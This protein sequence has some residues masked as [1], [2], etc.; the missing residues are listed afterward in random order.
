MDN[1]KTDKNIKKNKHDYFTL[2]NVVIFILIACA[3]IFVGKYIINSTISKS[4]EKEQI[5]LEQTKHWQ[6]KKI[7]NEIND[8]YFT[9]ATCT[10]KDIIINNNPVSL[11]LFIR[12]DNEGI[13]IS[14]LK[15]LESKKNLKIDKIALISD[16]NNNTLEYLFNTEE[17]VYN[18]VDASNI[19]DYIKSHKSLS[20]K[21]NFV[22]ID[23]DYIFSFEQMKEDL[24]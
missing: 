11:R 8:T 15:L 20:L 4:T 16:T 22:A 19:I 5:D 24:F 17:Q 18:F 21:V 7:Y 10:S 9:F 3:I 1:V 12:R 6:I 23:K 2:K 13:Y 14:Y